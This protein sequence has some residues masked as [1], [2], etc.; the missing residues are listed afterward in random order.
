[1]SKLGITLEEAD[2]TLYWL[3][4]IEETRILPGDVVASATKEASEIISILVASI[5][6]SRG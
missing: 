3:E 1:M 6:T 4:L 5:N 2:E